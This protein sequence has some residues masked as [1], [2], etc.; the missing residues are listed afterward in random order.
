[1]YGFIVLAESLIIIGLGVGTHLR[2][3]ILVGSAFVGVDALSS[4]SLAVRSGVNIAL[5]VFILAL[6]LI[7]TATL[8]SLRRPDSG[9]PPPAGEGPISDKVSP[10][11]K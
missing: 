10:G 9:Q 3:L 6:L 4:A 7:V 1:M 8:L 2:M 11:A 5:V